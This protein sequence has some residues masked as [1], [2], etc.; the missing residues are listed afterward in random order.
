MWEGVGAREPKREACMLRI[1]SVHAYMCKQ[2]LCVGGSLSPCQLQL[3]LWE[4]RTDMLCVYIIGHD[5]ALAE[6]HLSKHKK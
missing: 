5:N 3:V 1:S 6:M 2:M 4:L